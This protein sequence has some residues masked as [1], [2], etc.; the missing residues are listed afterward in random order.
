VLTVRIYHANDKECEALVK[1]LSENYR[2]LSASGDY[3]DRN[4]AYRRRYLEIEEV[5][6]LSRKKG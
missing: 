2:I 5:K 3:K 6:K 1:F 4:E